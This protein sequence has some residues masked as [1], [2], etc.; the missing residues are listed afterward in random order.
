MTQ[1]DSDIDRQ[2]HRQIV[3]LIDEDRQIGQTLPTY[4]LF[5]FSYSVSSDMQIDIWINRSIYTDRQLDTDRCIDRQIENIDRQ[6]GQTL[7][8]YNLFKFSS[9]AFLDMQ[10]DIWIIRSIYY[11]QIDIDR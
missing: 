2:L 4:N 8:T 1:I 11:I 6:I 7:L 10:I 5:Q 9:F 3:T